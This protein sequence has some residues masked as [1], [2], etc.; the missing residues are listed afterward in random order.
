MIEENSPT[1]PLRRRMQDVLLLDRLSDEI[2]KMIDDQSGCGFTSLLQILRFVDSPILKD[3]KQQEKLIQVFKEMFGSLSADLVPA[4]IVKFCKSYD[5]GIN[6]IKFYYDWNLGSQEDVTQHLTSN[7]QIKISFPVHVF[8]PDLL[9]VTLEPNQ[10]A[11]IGLESQ[12]KEHGHY[13][14]SD[15]SDF[16]GRLSSG[17]AEVL[18]GYIK[19]GYKVTEIFVFE[20]PKRP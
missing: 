14:C 15:K 7:G 18:R 20:K 11:I 6:I 1:L 17:G 3:R 10:V 19:N 13:I 12:N 2:K 8:R 4:D 5:L 16:M 9:Q